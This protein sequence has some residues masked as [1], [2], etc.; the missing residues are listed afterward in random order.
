MLGGEE[1]EAIEKTMKSEDEIKR[2][3]KR[4][5]EKEYQSPFKI[6]IVEVDK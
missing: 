2:A 5:S 3:L 6:E 4:A 1:I